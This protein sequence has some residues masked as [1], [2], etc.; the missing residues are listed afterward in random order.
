MA[1]NFLREARPPEFFGIKPIELHNKVQTICVILQGIIGKKAAT[2]VP[3][4]TSNY[5][6]CGFD[7]ANRCGIPF[8]KSFLAD[9]QYLFLKYLYS[10][11]Y[12]ITP[13]RYLTSFDVKRNMFHSFFGTVKGEPSPYSRSDTMNED[14]PG[15]VKLPLSPQSPPPPALLTPLPANSTTNEDHHKNIKIPDLPMS[16]PQNITAHEDALDRIKPSDISQTLPPLPDSPDSPLQNRM[17][18]ESAS[19]DFETP[20]FSQTIPRDQ[21]VSFAKASRVLGGGNQQ[22]FTFTVLSPSINGAFRARRADPRNIP[23]MFVALKRPLEP[24]ES[25]STIHKPRY[26]AQSSGK[27]L[28]LTSFASIIEEAKSKHLKGV[29]KVPPGQKVQ[30]LIKRFKTEEEL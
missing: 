26:L 13:K 2:R 8:E 30:V 28:K 15:N 16:P 6:N 5:D 14:V 21:I 22:N 27:G 1:E 29:L 12:S 11:S 19:G 24:Q 20:G 10:D 3:E 7:I 17:A 18:P 9:R 4:L 25:Q 23:S